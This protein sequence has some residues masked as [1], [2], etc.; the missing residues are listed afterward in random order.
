MSHRK[1]EPDCQFKVCYKCKSTKA[2]SD[3]YQ[4]STRYDGLSQGCK[5]CRQAYAKVYRANNRT[6][7]SADNK[8]YQRR[9][10][11]VIRRRRRRHR[12]Y[13]RDPGYKISLLLRSRLHLAIIH[14]SKAGS[15]IKL[16]GCTIPEFRAY[17][18]SRF[19]PGMSWKNHAVDGW[20]IDHIKP[21]VSFDLQDPHQLAR[22]CHYT[23]LQPLW[24]EDNLRKNAKE[25]H[26]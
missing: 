24:A 4:V 11:V 9:E 8:D 14:E 23:N 1:N 2:R 15:A 5:A 3:F 13:D 7:L 20:H 26:A 17:L 6:K 19:K 22:A 18:E 21:L 10:D 16:L 25:N 12:R